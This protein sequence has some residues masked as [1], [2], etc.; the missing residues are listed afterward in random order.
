MVGHSQIGWYESARDASNLRKN[1]GNTASL[2]FAP[3]KLWS[4][5]PPDTPLCIF[6]VGRHN[7]DHNNHAKLKRVS[8]EPKKGTDMKNAQANNGI[9]F[10]SNG[11]VFKN[12]GIVFSQDGIV[13]NREGIVFGIVF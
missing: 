11:I 8:L 5:V 2:G 1:S 3:K 9:V 13:F 7:A 12:E 6:K 10:G 4:S